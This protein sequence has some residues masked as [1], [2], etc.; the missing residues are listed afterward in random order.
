MNK[1]EKPDIKI[2]FIV[3]KHNENEIGRFM[4]L[5]ER[6]KVKA[7][8]IPPCVRNMEQAKEMLPS[9][10][11]YWIYDEEEYKK[12]RLIPKKNHPSGCPWIIILQC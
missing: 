9:D 11:K 6:L 7:E 4:D 12:G 2:G 5:A 10:R 8:L 1:T 3:M